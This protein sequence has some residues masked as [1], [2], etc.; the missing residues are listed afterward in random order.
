MSNLLLLT[1]ALQ[2]SAEVLPALGLLLHSVRVAPAE[3][4]ALL[5]AAPADAVLVDARRELV[6]AKSLCRLL[7]T[8]GL[9]CPL[10]VIVTE[11]GLAAMTAEWGADDVILDS[12]GP[13]EVEARLRMAVGRMNL[14]AAEEVP[15]EIRS[16]DLSIDEATY[17]ARLRGRAL[18]LTFKE[19]ELLKYLAQHPGR[20]FTRAQLL[21][22]VWGYDY[23]GGTR[24]VDV[25]VRRLR[26]KLGAEYESLIGT[27]R[28]VGYRFVPERGGEAA[29]ER[30]PAH[31]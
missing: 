13:A 12:A 22:E 31:H 3:A 27:V 5:D 20:V 15:D 6:Q 7:R 21:Q 28:N 25:H 14:S 26:A 11:G 10:L 24:T 16:G 18:D 19:F 17:T 8:T 2:P 30:E 9:D 29:E 4:S 1:N 23:F